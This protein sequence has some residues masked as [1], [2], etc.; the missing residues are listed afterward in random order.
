MNENS[1]SFM[2]CLLF[3]CYY[4]FA[5][6]YSDNIELARTTE[7]FSKALDQILEDEEKKRKQ[8]VH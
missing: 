8:D 3:I 2:T 5:D 6:S 1:N 7:K 4:F